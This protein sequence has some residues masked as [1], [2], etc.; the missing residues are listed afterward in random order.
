[1]NVATVISE[2]SKVSYYSECATNEMKK[3][4][5]DEA[6][7]INMLFDIQRTLVVIDKD[8]ITDTSFASFD[9]GKLSRLSIGLSRVLS[10]F[11]EE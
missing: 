1:M 9:N 2:L 3:I 5:I 11:I 6:K 7:V 4:P 8:L 10:N